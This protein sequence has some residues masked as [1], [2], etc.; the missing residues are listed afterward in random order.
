MKIE[1]QQNFSRM[2]ESFDIDKLD[3]LR[4][5]LVNKQN[6]LDREDKIFL[7][8]REMDRKIKIENHMRRI[9]A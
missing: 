8:E 3:R 4:E 1:N 9:L 2:L 5:I 7:I 6:E